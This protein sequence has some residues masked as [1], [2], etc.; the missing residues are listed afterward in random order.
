MARAQGT[1][2]PQLKPSCWNGNTF[3][4]GGRWRA[5]NCGVPNIKSVS[6]DVPAIEQPN[7]STKA[8]ASFD[9]SPCFF[10]WTSIL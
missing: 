3:E 9:I 7:G 5:G 6:N 4:P 10:S 2:T 8:S 1:A